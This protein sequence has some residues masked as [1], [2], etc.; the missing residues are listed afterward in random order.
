MDWLSEIENNIIRPS[1]IPA[2]KSF[3]ETFAK[4]LVDAFISDISKAGYIVD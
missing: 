4:E 2:N 3:A 1:R